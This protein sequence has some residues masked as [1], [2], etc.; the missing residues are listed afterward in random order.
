MKSQNDKILAYI[1]RR[2]SIT[3]LDAVR[4]GCLRLAARISDLRDMGIQIDSKL[5]TKRKK[6]YARYTLA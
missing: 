4:F 6:T 2:G 5:E 3:A 1:K